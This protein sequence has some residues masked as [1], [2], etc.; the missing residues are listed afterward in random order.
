MLGSAESL[1]QVGEHEGALRLLTRAQ[2][3]GLEPGRVLVLLARSELALGRSA[4]AAAH[5]RSALALDG[6]PY[7]EAHLDEVASALAEASAAH[8]AADVAQARLD[9]TALPAGTR[10]FEGDFE[11]GVAPAMLTVEPGSH[12][13]R[14]VAPDGRQAQ[15]SVSVWPN[16]VETLHVGASVSPFVDLASVPPSATSDVAPT[17]PSPAPRRDPIRH[18]QGITLRWGVEAETDLPVAP[19]ASLGFAAFGVVAGRLGYRAVIAGDVQ[20]DHPDRTQEFDDEGPSTG[21]TVRS[22]DGQSRRIFVVAEL[23]AR[24]L[25][26]RVL[27]LEAGGRFGLR[28]TAWADATLT[29]RTPS[30]RYT[31]SRTASGTAWQLDPVLQGGIGLGLNFGRFEVAARFYVGTPRLHFLVEAIIPFASHS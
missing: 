9:T 27:F 11:I 1:Q 15:V 10:V 23:G 22:I 16:G 7:V 6:D 5:L 31:Q 30:R 26:N 28:W 3:R 25:I 8:R 29:Y 13:L 20:L 12:T 4:D 19:V 2:V 24:L 14:L 17:T 18:A 21:V